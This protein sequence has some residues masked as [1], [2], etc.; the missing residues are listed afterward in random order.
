MSWMWA[1]SCG[2]AA[3][4]SAGISRVW[5]TGRAMRD[6]QEIYVVEHLQLQLVRRDVAVH[7]HR[8]QQGRIGLERLLP[9]GQ[10]SAPRGQTD[11]GVV[12]SAGDAHAHTGRALGELKRHRGVCVGLMGGADLPDREPVL[13]EGACLA[14]LKEREVRLVVGVH[15]RHQLDVGTVFVGEVAV[16]RVAKSVVAPGPLLLA[17]GDVVIG[18]VH[19]AACSAWSYPPKK[20]S[21]VPA[22]M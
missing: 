10:H 11:G 2:S 22:H 9:T 5:G 14:G 1:G 21:F 7:R 20:S 18:D 8:L 12:L 15:A 13:A 4:A 19:D 17:R 16:P 6:Q 3:S